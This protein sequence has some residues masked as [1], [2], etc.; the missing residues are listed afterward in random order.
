MRNASRFLAILGV[1]AVIVAMSTPASA[2]CSPPKSMSSFTSNLAN[3]VYIDFGSE[4]T[5]DAQ[6]TGFF[7]DQGTANSGTLPAADYMFVDVSGKLSISGNLGDARVVGCPEGK[8]ILR[9]QAQTTSGVRFLT[10][11]AQEG[12][13]NPTGANFDFSFGH[14]AN[15]SFTGALIPR[16]KVTSSVRAGGVVNVNVN[17]DATGSANPNNDPAGAVTGYE[18]LRAAGADPGRNPAGWAVVQTVAAPNGAAATASFAA[19]CSNPSQDQFF[20]TRALFGTQKSDLVSNSTRVNCNPSLAEPR[21]NVVPK[22]PT[23]PRKT[24][25]R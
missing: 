13:S 14:P 6:V 9:L 4:V 2:V 1:A 15:T 24:G 3:Y 20:A 10:L 19:D 7:Y 8:I 11:T 22:K 12:I 17:L 16:P 18:I 25:Q 21:F 5:S 23:G